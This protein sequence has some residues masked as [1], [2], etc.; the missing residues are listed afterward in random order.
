MH[1]RIWA[2]NNSGGG[3]TFYFTAKFGMGGEATPAIVDADA[4]PAAVSPT[5]LRILVVD[6]SEDSRFLVAESL[7]KLGCQLDYAENG[8]IAFDKFAAGA[9]DL[10]LMDLQ[11]PAM[12]GYAATQRIRRWEE[13]QWR[14]RTPIV[15]L[16]ASALDTELQKALAAGCTACLRKPLRPVAVADA[17][18]KYAAARQ[19]QAAPASKKILI[20]ADPRLRAAIPAYLDK[21]RDDAR[22]IC[23]A[24][25]RYDYDTIRALGH[26][27]NGTGGGFGFPRISEIGAQLEAAAKK[28]DASAIH[29][30]IE[31]LSRYLE[32]VEPV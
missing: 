3:A 27:M 31:E 28:Q 19:P 23:A 22:K 11:M 26:K 30:Q 8:Q 2:E 17:V 12:D 25:E 4:E 24:L 20:R 1:G 14:T 21:R 7:S 9:Y 13:E 6:D 5:S 16:T 18:R 15:A 29:A 32:H 10:V